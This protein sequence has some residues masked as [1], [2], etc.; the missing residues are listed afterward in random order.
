MENQLFPE[1]VLPGALRH[2]MKMILQ[3][4]EIP[5]AGTMI[6]IAFGYTEKEEACASNIIISE[7]EVTEAKEL[8]MVRTAISRFESAVKEHTLYKEKT[9]VD[10]KVKLEVS[11]R[12]GKPDTKWILGFLLLALKDLQNGFLAVG[13]QTAIGR[14]VFEPDGPILID[15]KKEDAQFI[16]EAFKSLEDAKGGK[17]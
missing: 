7:A 4:L 12:K 15:G 17:R 1:A 3:E 14:G 2:R 5:E 8:T 16:Q 13:G 10:G 9:Y 6:Q 11:V